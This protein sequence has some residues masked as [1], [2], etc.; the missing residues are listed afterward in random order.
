MW[1]VV[2]ACVTDPK[3]SSESEEWIDDEAWFDGEI[4][5]QTRRRL[6]R[7]AFAGIGGAGLAGLA[8]CMGDG[9]PAG[10]DTA[11]GGGT[12]AI[13]ADTATTGT[14]T[15]STDTGTATA[16]GGAGSGQAVLDDEC[17]VDPQQANFNFYNDGFQY[18]FR[19]RWAHF[20]ELATHDTVSGKTKG[21]IISDWSYDDNGR[22]TWTLNENYTWHNGDDLT[23]ED[24]V[25]QLKIGQ[26]MGFVHKG[27]GPSPGYENVQ[28]TGKYELQFDL[29]NPDI[30][31]QIFHSSHLKRRTWMWAY[32]GIWGQY[33][34]AFEDT[35]GESA[36][37]DLR[38]EVASE[39]R[40]PIVSN[41]QVPGN[42]PW[43]HHEIDG[44]TLKF[45][46]HEEYQSPFSQD[47]T[48]SDI[49]YSYE[50]TF[51]TSQQ[52][53]TAAMQEGI[54]DVSYPPNSESARQQLRDKGWEGSKGLDPEEIPPTVRRLSMGFIFNMQDAITGNRKV[55]QAIAH[56]IPRQNMISWSQDY[57]SLYIQD[58]H[59]SGL[60]QDKE[61]L[62]FGGTDGWPNER[63]SS[64]P[65]YAFTE[66]DVDTQRATELLEEAGFSKSGN[67]WQD[68]DGQPVT[69]D[70]YTQTSSQNPVQLRAAQVMKSYLDGFGLNAEVTAQQDSIRSSNTQ[71]SGNWHIMPHNP[72]SVVSG[73]PFFDFSLSFQFIHG[74]D[75]EVLEDRPNWAMDMEVEVPY[76]IGDPDGDLETV[77][78]H[79]KVY[80]LRT[81]MPESERQELVEELAWIYNQSL[82]LLPTCEEGGQSPYWLDKSKWRTRGP[83][84]GANPAYRY[85]AVEAGEYAYAQYMAKFANEWFGPK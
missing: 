34:E 74:P 33:A 68:P 54:L 44:Q 75:G 10:T 41:E 26:L 11:G 67:R 22:G 17:S 24:V 35:S 84:D 12:D 78:V 21:M 85:L 72:G 23:A 27:Y 14:G 62:W 42:G 50:S 53:R 77:N 46:P 25:T 51:Y 71:P 56:V 45:K 57:P 69:L 66:D 29:K 63:L 49:N 30:N 64:F 52:Q 4:A 36:L 48:G 73:P 82:P 3:S 19:W 76:P 16:G 61:V 80:S 18:D 28:Q 5:P 81:Q 9:G 38:N 59:L 20:D 43:N 39:L 6:L 55:R 13:T 2:L 32:R 70:V 58:E 7:N 40:E 8:G 37:N 60:G 1:R 15:A 47:H 79:E 65:N 31:R 83:E